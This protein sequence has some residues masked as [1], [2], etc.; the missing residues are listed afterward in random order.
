VSRAEF[1][2]LLHPGIWM[3]VEVRAIEGGVFVHFWD[4]TDA[5]PAKRGK[6]LA[7][8]FESAMPPDETAAMALLDLEGLIVTVNAHWQDSAMESRVEG[9]R[10][11]IGERYVDV[12]G[13]VIPNLN[14]AELR[15]GVTDVATCATD[16]FTNAYMVV[17]PA[18]LRWRQVRISRIEVAG[19]AYLIAIHEDLEDLARAQAAVRKALENQISAREQEREHIAAELHDSTGQHLA[20]LSMGIARLRR[21]VGAG[22]ESTQEV[23]R[24]MAASLHEAVR[25]IRVFSYLMQ[26]PQL[27]RDGLERT[28]RSLVAGFGARSGLRVSCT[29]EGHAE[30]ANMPAQQAM[31]RVIQEALSNV[32]RHAEASAVAVEVGCHGTILSIRVA[33]DGKGIES[34]RSGGPEGGWVGVGTTSMRSR[35]EELGGSF[36]I[37][38][39]AIGT[40]VAAS[41]P[42]VGVDH[43]GVSPAERLADRRRP[44]LNQASLG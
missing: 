9:Q 3:E 27:R 11:G 4:A 18:G 13:R 44:R 33:D 30:T 26:P 1:R 25:E 19:A 32:H 23:I 43:G 42:V 16:A 39:D 41:I 2:S 14:A 17:T 12:C 5:R 34:L 15:Q 35:V 28:V 7:A 24:D 40:I 37:S 10:C 31:F 21:L 8:N 36:A 29:V 20:A 38:C 6:Q 22:E